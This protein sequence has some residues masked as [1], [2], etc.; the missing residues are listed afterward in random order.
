MLSGERLQLLGR[1]VLQNAMGVQPLERK[2]A[3]LLAYLALEGRQS[4]SKLAGLLWG[5]TTETTAR[6]NLAQTLARVRKQHG[7]IVLG[8]SELH[9]QIVDVDALSLEMQFFRG[10]Y[11]AVAEQKSEF[12]SDLDFEDCPDFEE[13]VLAKR[14]QLEELSI[15]ACALQAEALA[16]IDTQAALY[17]AEQYR[18]RRPESE[19]AYQRLMR[20]YAAL[21]DSGRM[22]QAFKQCQTM[23]ASVFQA[24]PSATT[25]ALLEQLKHPNKA[26]TAT[27]QKLEPQRLIGRE[28]V[29]QQIV[30]AWANHQ[31]V[32]LRGAP[33][34]GKSRLTQTVLSQQGSS[35]YATGRPGDSSAAYSTQA[36]ALR[37]VLLDYPVQLPDWVRLELS[38]ILPELALLTD[39]LAPLTS[40]AEQLRFY[41]AQSELLRLAQQA[42][43]KHIALD[44]LQFVDEAS[45]QASLFMLQPHWGSDSGIRTLLAYRTGELSQGSL[46]NLEQTVQSG[47]AVEIELSA[48]SATDIETLLEELQLE[49]RFAAPTLLEY[50]NGNPLYILETLRYSLENKTD[51]RDAPRIKSLIQS[52]LAALSPAAMRLA[53]V[54]AVLEQDFTLER[55][56]KILEQPVLEILPI[57]AE[58]ETSEVMKGERFVHDLIFEAVQQGIS[59][60]VLRFLHG[61]SAE[62]LEQARLEG[63]AALRI[64]IHY[65]K[66]GETRK[67]IPLLEQAAKLF[68]T[69]LRLLEAAAARV[70]AA[71]AH[72]ALDAH[73]D[74]CE[75]LNLASNFYL[76][77]Q[78]VSHYQKLLPL[79]E[80]NAKTPRHR[81]QQQIFRA[82]LHEWAGEI[83][84]SI[85]ALE[86]GFREVENT[87][88]YSL[89]ASSLCAI[90]TQYW[91]KSDFKTS[92]EYIQRGLEL[93]LL[94]REKNTDQNQTR[95]IDESIAASHANLAATLDNLGELKSAQF[96]HHECIQVFQR[97]NERHRLP[98]TFCNYAINLMDQGMYPSALDWLRQAL[99]IGQEFKDGLPL[100]PIITTMSRC[101]QILGMPFEALKTL[102]D[103]F[104]YI[105]R[106]Q[107]VYLPV[108]HS[109]MAGCW[110]NLGQL[111]QA[112]STLDSIPATDIPIFN[113][114]IEIGRAEYHQM[115]G[116]PDT[117][118]LEQHQAEL[119]PERQV[120][121]LW[122]QSLSKAPIIA[123]QAAENAIQI[124]QE[125]GYTGMLH[126][127][128]CRAANAALRLGDAALALEYSTAALELPEGVTPEIPM[129]E[130][131][132]VHFS[133]LQAN[134]QDA[135]STL[136]R[137]HQLLLEQHAALPL[138]YQNSFLEHNPINKAVLEAARKAGLTSLP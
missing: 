125:R 59:A 66:A 19:L 115:L 78:S 9:L 10:E 1:P 117:T 135:T 87:D 40:E 86:I 52:R 51:L 92:L 93:H 126:S 61:R 110:R 105:E 136:Q 38:R 81:A 124:S 12:L 7:E 26:V 70:Q 101:Q 39:T 130:L 3:G 132:L 18:Q 116:K 127:S 34:I 32:V 119:S 57:H 138:E 91:Y 98:T 102:Q 5:N 77:V 15:E 6:N 113:Q 64:A 35:V 24:E 20:L 47:L 75:E 108:V 106:V 85:K 67:S 118:W 55:A 100:T 37:Q 62:I 79:Y 23:L 123:L 83:D 17:W 121:L 21:G 31:A 45:W 43:L 94:D 109:R 99:S 107:S 2:Q 76:Q 27:P 80:Q 89:Q 60:A 129:L 42:G 120:Q 97:I 111:Q 33:G 49:P 11:K 8:S 134:G 69:Q 73:E 128:K 53:Q 72:F 36:R 74:G 137:A 95:A 68:E 28:A 50:T 14:L 112:Q 122:L 71:E 88:Q 82:R 114:I 63:S 133:A 131:L 48:L 25:L 13:W 65:Q 46:E 16:P 22:H 4:R 44:D 58:L 104:E 30:Q 103:N 41:Q 96:H 29:W 84:Q 56:A 90:G 54:A